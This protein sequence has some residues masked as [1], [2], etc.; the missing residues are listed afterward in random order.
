M[1]I[2]IHIVGMRESFPDKCFT[3]GIIFI[4]G[5]RDRFPEA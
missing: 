5:K 1:F 4:L 2:S 3:F